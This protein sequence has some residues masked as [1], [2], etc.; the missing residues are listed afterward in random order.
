[1]NAAMDRPRSDADESPPIDL[2]PIVDF[3]NV[4]RLLPYDDWRTS[5]LAFGNAPL[6]VGALVLHG[7][8]SNL[9]FRAV[10]QAAASNELLSLRLTGIYR[11]RT[12]EVTRPSLWYLYRGKASVLLA[13]D[14]HRTV[15]GPL[16]QVVNL[17]LE[18]AA[19][20]TWARHDAGDYVGH[21]IHVEFAP[22]GN[23]AL[24][25]V[26]FADAKPRIAATL[27]ST[28]A[29]AVR[30]A[31]GETVSDVAGALADAL[32]AALEALESGAAGSDD[33][34]LVNWLVAHDALLPP[35][36]LDAADVLAREVQN[37][38]AKRRALE[39]KLPAPEYVL[40]LLDGS[41]V[42]EHV[43]LRGSHKRVAKNPTPRRMLTALGGEFD[44]PQGSGRLELAERIASP[45]NPLTARV[46]VNRVWTHLTG[47]GI[48]RTVDNFGVLGDRPTHP[49]LL[50]Y[51]AAEFVDNGWDVKQMIR[52]VVLSSTYR[53]ASAP[54][55]EISPGALASRD[56]A[57]QLLHCARVR[58]IPAEAIRD[59]LF[60]VAG[61]LDRKSFGP[62]IPVHI[63][64]FM[65]HNRSPEASGPR[66]GERR[67]SIY[68]EYRRN[69]LNHFLTAFDKP[70]PSTTIGHR[71]QSNSAAQPLMLLNDPLVH[72]LTQTWA[73]RLADSF[74]DDAAAIDSAYLTAY[75]RLP[76]ETE[77]SAI[78]RFLRQRP[79]KRQEAWSDVCLALVNNKEFIFL[80]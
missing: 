12:F 79:D 52:R 59:A 13:V 64:D 30:D 35:P 5:G 37:Y 8:K 43:H 68:I 53:Q 44:I 18:P 76:V 7:E 3:S 69:G 28:V 36:H 50:D 49:L 42:D 72:D 32:V 80:R 17:E 1:M 74:D 51:L 47:R 45:E 61:V 77:R 31:Q 11:T 65:R 39:K 75:G 40:A 27:N 26:A 15:E 22:E 46:F 9:P 58:R 23:F 34:R 25:A 16:H 10:E 62:S 29:K 60:A 67:R 38:R 48:V 54:G 4:S 6:S 20:W 41:G 14:S 24:A 55:S 70:L 78:I 19:N 56:P 71:H 57:N 33:A 63:T 66:D 73:N 21:R 2:E